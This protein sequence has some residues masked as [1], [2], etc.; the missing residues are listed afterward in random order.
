MGG[1]AKAGEVVAAGSLRSSDQVSE[2][3]PFFTDTRGLKP[4][5]RA[6]S[7]TGGRDDNRVLHR[8]TFATGADNSVRLKPA[9]LQF[10]DPD[11]LVRVDDPHRDIR[12]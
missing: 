12:W 8:E 3:T 9:D 11:V 4:A 7:S 1:L 5:G 6:A 10:P 2:V